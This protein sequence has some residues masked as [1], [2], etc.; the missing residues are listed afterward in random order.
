MRRVLAALEA[1]MWPGLHRKL[2]PDE[3]GGGSR[4]SVPAAG[5]SHFDQGGDNQSADHQPPVSTA[6]PAAHA[7]ASGNGGAAEPDEPFGSFFGVEDASPDDEADRK[8]AQL[9]GQMAGVI[10]TAASFVLHHQAGSNICE[11]IIRPARGDSQPA[12]LTEARS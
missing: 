9:M 11:P 10:L 7:D 3:R 12:C 2:Q 6:A 4:D 1:H 8:F 5:Q